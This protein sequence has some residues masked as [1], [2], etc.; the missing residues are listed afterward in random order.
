MITAREDTRSSLLSFE[1]RILED[2]RFPLKSNC[3]FCNLWVGKRYNGNASQQRVQPRL[4]WRLQLRWQRAQRQREPPQRE[5][6][7]RRQRVLPQ[8]QVQLLQ[9][10]RVLRRQRERQ[11]CKSNGMGQVCRLG[12]RG[13]RERELGGR[14][15][16]ACM[17]GQG[18][19]CKRGRGGQRV[20]IQ[21]RQRFLSIGHQRHNRHRVR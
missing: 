14:R 18:R 8:Q 15:E 13:R 9:R 16:R 6:P 19:V 1:A 5:Q 12:R 20:C 21:G 7:L 4:R 2:F 11:G 10:Q 3:S 17:L